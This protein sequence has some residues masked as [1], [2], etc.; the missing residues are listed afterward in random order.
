MQPIRCPH[1]LGV[2]AL[3]RLVASLDPG[4]A[5]ILELH[6]ILGFAPARAGPG[7]GREAPEPLTAPLA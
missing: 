2:K 1:L 3:T 4:G 7:A 5:Q 6:E